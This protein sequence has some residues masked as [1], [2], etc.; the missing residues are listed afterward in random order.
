M[1]SD[2]NAVATIPVKDINVARKFYADTLGLKALPGEERSVLEFKSGNSKVLVYESPYA[3]T[4]KATAA[5]WVIHHE[6][7]A[8]VD[9]LKEKGVEF[10]HYDF[11]ET[12]HDGDIHVMGDMRV[13]WLKDPDGN[14]LSLVSH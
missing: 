13:A 5:T 9:V 1:L 11:P 14:I 8:I 2:N 4:N 6:L 10:E 7:R 3:Q 12:T